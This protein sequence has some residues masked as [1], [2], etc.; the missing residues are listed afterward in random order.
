MQKVLACLRDDSAD[1]SAHINWVPYSVPA[2]LCTPISIGPSH[3]R[4]NTFYANLNRWKVCRLSPDIVP[5][6]Q[7]FMDMYLTDTGGR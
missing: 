3:R 7:E 1:D 5:I 6:L 2:L 4:S